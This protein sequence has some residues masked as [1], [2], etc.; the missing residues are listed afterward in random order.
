MKVK[1]LIIFTVSCL[2]IKSINAQTDI[3]ELKGNK[4]FS[5][6]Y[7]VKAN[8]AFIDV[9]TGHAAPYIYDFN[10]DGK[11]DLLVGEFGNKY[12]P[13]VDTTQ[14]H[15]YIQARCRIYLNHGSNEKPLY[16]D[17]TYLMA[18]GAPAF[19]PNT[20]CMCFVPRFVDLDGDGIDD[21]ITGSYPGNIYFFKGLGD[22]KYASG[23]TLTDYKGNVFEPAHSMPIEPVD[24]N[25]DGLIDLLVSSRGTGEFIILNIG[26]SKNYKFSAPQK[27][28][29]QQYEYLYKYYDQIRK[30]RPTHLITTDWDGDGLFDLIGG[31]EQS[32]IAFYKNIGSKSDPKFGKPELIWDM[33]EEQMQDTKYKLFGCRL[34]LFTYDYNSDGKD[35][36]LV[37]DVID[38]RIKIRELTPKE[39]YQKKILEDKLFVLGNELFGNGGGYRKIHDP[40]T[41]KNI[42]KELIKK[43]KQSDKLYSKLRKYD[44]YKS[45]GAHGYVWVLLRK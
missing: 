18:G 29:L 30:N 8:N 19:V 15:A 4:Y 1:F 39:E 20:C 22:Q 36:L 45:D 21:I 10:K 40:S 34:K 41:P 27:L 37:G 25:N 23:I 11:D 38:K 7:S 33:A 2:C 28:E 31:C 43:E 6:Y 3:I 9:Y 5:S 13:G 42:K 44:V 14:A 16:K 26:D 12:C 17:F 32:Q 35:D 24:W